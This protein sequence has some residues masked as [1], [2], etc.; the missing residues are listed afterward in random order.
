M[1]Y[2]IQGYTFSHAGELSASATNKVDADKAFSKMADTILNKLNVGKES[3]A[4][5][6]MHS[7]R[8]KPAKHIKKVRVSHGENGK[9]LVEDCR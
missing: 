1:A 5:I 2:L 4:I 7:T 3:S 6:T 9:P 8:G